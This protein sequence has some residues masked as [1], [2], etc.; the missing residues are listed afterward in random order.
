MT[1]NLDEIGAVASAT[2]ARIDPSSRVVPED[3]FRVIKEN[4]IMKQLQKIQTERTMARTRFEEEGTIPVGL[5]A[6]VDTE[7]PNG[8]HVEMV[9]A[10]AFH[11]KNPHTIRFIDP[12]L[13]ER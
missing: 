13:T 3:Y 9:P 7:A 8:D 1:S 10:S 12:N 11:N 2:K 5:K 6:Q 4:K